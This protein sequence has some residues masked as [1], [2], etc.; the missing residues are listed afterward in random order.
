MIPETRSPARGRIVAVVIAIAMVGGALA[1][2]A[3]VFDDDDSGGSSGGGSTETLRVAC[4]AELADVCAELDA[5]VTVANA[6]DTA[7]ALIA[8]TGSR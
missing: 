8:A 7:A 2:R 1:I 6:G 4:A 5:E 3:L